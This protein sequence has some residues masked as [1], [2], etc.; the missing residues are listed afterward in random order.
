[1]ADRYWVGGSGTWS[2]SSTTN[3]SATSGGSS[4][5]S[6]PTSNDNVIFNSASSASS[7]SVALA[8]DDNL[9]AQS[10]TIDGPASGTLSISS[11]SNIFSL[12]VSSSLTVASSGVSLTSFA[13]TIDIRD[14][15]TSNISI[16]PA[17]TNGTLRIDQANGSVKRLTASLVCKN[18]YI[19]DA[20]S[21]LTTNGYDI[22]CSG[23]LSIG[24][25]FGGAAGFITSGT[26]SIYLT[27]NNQ[28][29]YQIV[30][31]VTNTGTVN[32]RC[33]YAGSTGTRTFSL[34]QA[35]TTPAGA[36]NIYISA[37]SDT[38]SMFTSP[39][40]V[41]QTVDFT[42]FSGSLSGSS[43]ATVWGSLTFS[44]GMTVSGFTGGINM[45]AI[46]AGT[47]TLTT[48]GKS[49]AFAFGTATTT[50]YVGSVRLGGA[51]TTTKAIT[52]SAASIPLNTQGYA[53]TSLSF[54]QTAGTLTLGATTWTLTGSGTVLTLGTGTTQSLGTSTFVFTSASS[55]TA[56]VN[57][58][59]LP[60]ITQSGAGLLILTYTGPI[61]IANLTTTVAP[62]ALQFTS[63]RTA[64]ITGNFNVSG[65]PGNLVTIT[66]SSSGT[67][68][69]LSKSSGVINSNYLSLKDS[70]ATGGATW[71]AGSGST[72]VS[73]NT[74]WIFADTFDSGMLF[75]FN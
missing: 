4:G 23:L 37:G 38:V 39:N 20:L 12:N 41:T 18:L 17:L 26:E 67:A 47:S 52:M 57:A 3:W 56:T 6:V 72:N 2:S 42:G 14:F 69:T 29:I 74:G 8:L 68:A 5:A 10:L 65:T 73:G 30:G 55:K 58:N 16:G 22:T 21:K 7:Y 64:T 33:T 28:T 62:T 49:C 71:F 51:F 44:S 24:S 70:T 63:S 1:M 54:S 60:S 40:D 75:F 59:N 32:I 13:G 45:G 27:G 36:P 53:V 25:T 66:S 31:T 15:S 50:G 43:T 11:T 35:G 46:T 34:N 48:A 19:A 9:Y 61:N